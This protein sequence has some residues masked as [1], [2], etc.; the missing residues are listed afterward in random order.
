MDSRGFIL[1][2]TVMLVILVLVIGLA[3]LELAGTEVKLSGN[4][5]LALEALYLAEAGVQM[6]LHMLERDPAWQQGYRNYPLGRGVIKTV[7]VTHEGNLVTIESQ[8]EVLGVGRRI[9][10]QLEKVPV[11]FTHVIETNSLDL[12]PGAMVMVEGDAVHFGDFAL[13]HGE[14]DA[15]LTVE[16]SVRLAG[17]RFKG[18]MAATGAIT[19]YPDAQVEGTLI[20]AKEVSGVEG[21]AGV[22]VI[23]PAGSLPPDLHWYYQQP[24]FPVE[25]PVL[26]LGELSSGFYIAGGDLTLVGQNPVSNYQGSVAVVVPGTLFVHCNLIPENPELDTLVLAAERIVV[27]PWVTDC[28][29][30]FLAAEEIQIEGGTLSRKLAGSLVAP[31]ISI[32]PGQVTLSYYPF[33]GAHLVKQPQMLL[34]VNKWQEIML[35]K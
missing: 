7:T 11:P 19:V 33:P 13:A 4:H 14:L 28:A 17:G 15:L 21:Y 22:P 12:R 18:A 27:S 29:G 25:E 5:K 3:T 31:R 9:R 34:Q 8:G 24:R 26:D 1:F 30:I 35:M 10:V 20:S 16:G 32:G 23:L 6:A 2:P